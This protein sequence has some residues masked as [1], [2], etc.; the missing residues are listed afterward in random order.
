MF[1]LLTSE[2]KNRLRDYSN[3]AAAPA[4][5]AAMPPAPWRLL[6]PD[7]DVELLE[8]LLDVE[9]PVV[10]PDSEDVVVPVLPE[11][12][13]VEVPVAFAVAVVEYCEARAQYWVTS[14]WYVLWRASPGQLLKHLAK[15]KRHVSHVTQRHKKAKHGGKRTA[16]DH[17]SR[18]DGLVRIALARVVLLAAVFLD[19][20]S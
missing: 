13:A 2:W 15:R 6:A 14:P 3:R 16:G 9:V 11:E 5:T 10:V 8:E 7:S 18:H 19:G 1:V 20:L 12:L 4:T 17:Y